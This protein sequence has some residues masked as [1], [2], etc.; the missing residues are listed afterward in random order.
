MMSTPRPASSLFSQSAARPLLRSTPRAVA[1]P[2]WLAEP[3]SVA[4]PSCPWPRLEK[5]SSPFRQAQPSLAQPSRTQ[6]SWTVAGQLARFK[7]GSEAALPLPDAAD[8]ERS[9]TRK[10]LW[11]RRN[12]HR[13]KGHGWKLVCPRTQLLAPRISRAGC[14]GGDIRASNFEITRGT[15]AA[16]CATDCTQV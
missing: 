1:D 14:H 2:T 7:V 8:E 16:Y 4:G 3:H 15:F 6:R 13:Q 9:L 12:K 10:S 11:H 5:G